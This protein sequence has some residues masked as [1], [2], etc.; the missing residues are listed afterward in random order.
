MRHRKLRVSLLMGFGLA[1]GLMVWPGCPP[2]GT[3]A[4]L[5]TRPGNSGFV[6]RTL[7]PEH[8]VSITKGN[9]AEQLATNAQGRL[10]ILSDFL[11]QYQLELGS[12]TLKAGGMS[13]VAAAPEFESVIGDSEQ[14]RT[15]LLH[16][17]YQGAL[18]LDAVQSGDFVS[19]DSAGGDQLRRVQAR[20]FDTSVLPTPPPSNSD[21]RAS[22]R[23]KFAVYLRER[24]MLSGSSSV[25]DT[26]VIWAAQN[27]AGFLA[28][29]TEL[30]DEIPD[31]AQG[32][33]TAV[34]NPLT[35]TITVM[36]NID[37]CHA[38]VGTGELP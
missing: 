33:L 36:S 6:N 15:V 7:G 38:G 13:F 4:A 12:I 22:A 37:A 34:V 20:L 1:L 30:P 8:I 19:N 14:H 11:G 2:S 25:L 28:V 31:T 27:V 32:R 23:S 18:I 29:Y 5:A 9:L 16:Q 35:N 21:T 3:L 17:E 10:N 26:P 24:G